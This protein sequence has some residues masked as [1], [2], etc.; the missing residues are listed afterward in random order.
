MFSDG[1]ASFEFVCQRLRPEI[2][3]YA[4]PFAFQQERDDAVIDAL[5]HLPRPAILYVTEKAA[6]E[7]FASTLRSEGFRRL[8]CFHGDTRKRDRSD[9]LRR[10]K[11]NEL[12]LMVATSAFGVGVDKP[13]VRAV[14][15]ACYPE[16]LDRYYQEVGRG[17]RDGWSSVSLLLPAQPDRK[18]ADGIS[19]RLMSP[20]LI[21]ERW[22][23][24]F[25][26]AE[27]REGYTYALPMATRHTRLVG[28]R[29]YGENI[30]WNK[31][32]LLQLERADQLAL[33]DLELRDPATADDDPEEWAI[34]RVKFPPSTPRLA[35]LITRQREEELAHFRGS[36][37]NLDRFLSCEKCA[38]RVIGGLYDF[39]PH[40]RACPGCS[41]CRA[42]DRQPLPCE[43]LD[44]PEAS[45][46][47]QAGPSEL[48]EA[49][50][51]PLTPSTRPDF[52]E[53]ISRCTNDKGL[54]QYF[55]PTET[56]GSVLACFKVAFP[57][58]APVLN[59]V[60]PLS[61]ISKVGSA[62]IFP[63]AFIHVGSIS[64]PALTLARPFPAVHLLC[65]VTNVADSNGRD[66]AVTENFRVWPSPQ[67][68]TA[69]PANNSLPC[70]PTTP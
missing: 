20:E 12:D 5:W 32:L 26:S 6:A 30:R 28:T 63:L 4:H 65:G 8:G 3:Y 24:M 68:W 1:N 11:S 58:N 49:C 15:H 47:P 64:S 69:E 36:F 10:W 22:S 44:F 60:D 56:F 27:H 9:L 38:S 34:V 46:R 16:N 37:E 51:S 31:R 19:V 18:V 2:Q 35:E 57:A 42:H 25:N 40:Q 70:L 52:I 13:D 55:C 50:P 33:L 54:R 29:T 14:V 61:V 62:T 45:L 39:A 7:W 48:I 17:G 53:L 41:Y 23:A 43:P 59:R 66:I 21:Q 67:V